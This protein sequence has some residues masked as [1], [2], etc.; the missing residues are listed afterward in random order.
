MRS[1]TSGNAIKIIGDSTNDSGRILWRNNGDTSVTASIDV[2]SSE[3]MVFGTGGSTERM[4]IDSSGN[5]LVGKTSTSSALTTAGVDLRPEGRSFMTRSAGPALYL[6]RTTSDGNIAEF[7]KDGTTVGSI[8]NATGTLVV[9]SPDGSGSYLRFGSNNINPTTSAGALRDAAID[10]GKTGGRF[11]DLYLSGGVYLGGTGAANK[12]EDY[13]KGSF[14]PQIGDVSGNTGTLTTALG[15]YTKVGRQVTIVV[16]MINMD[17]TALVSTEQFRIKNLPFS[18]FTAS[19]GPTFTS[20]AQVHNIGASGKT[21]IAS[22]Q[23]QFGYVRLK[24]A[25]SGLSDYLLVSDI[26][27]SSLADIRFSLTYFTA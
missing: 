7:Y 27:Q 3:D 22:I 23:D 16:D 2:N 15:Y 24:E 20:I 13:E 10:L 5:L 25:D 9:G 11:K 6:S 1:G 14:T 8:G 4:R 19:G 18:A 17:T 26:G 21:I 12:L